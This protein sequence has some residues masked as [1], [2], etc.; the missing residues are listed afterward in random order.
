MVR[1]TDGGG[2]C[3]KKVKRIIERC[4]VTVFGGFHASGMMALF[5][6]FYIILLMC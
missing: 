1:V 2:G 6:V 5:F 4:N 3:G